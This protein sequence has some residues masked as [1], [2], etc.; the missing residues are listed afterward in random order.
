MKYHVTLQWNG[1]SL[2]TAARFYG[3]AEAIEMFMKK[4]RTEDS[5]FAGDQVHKIYLYNTIEEA[6]DHQKIYGGEILEI[7]DEWLEIFEDVSEGTPMLAVDR[8]ID[9][10]YIRRLS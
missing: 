6:R 7:D 8:E 9:Q 2:Q 3:E 1:K 4:W 10:K 5:A